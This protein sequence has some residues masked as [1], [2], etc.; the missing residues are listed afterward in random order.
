MTVTSGI[1][2]IGN[3]F[4]RDNL[5]RSILGEIETPRPVANVGNTTSS[6]GIT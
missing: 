2:E 1:N 6:P 4:L 3:A 5:M